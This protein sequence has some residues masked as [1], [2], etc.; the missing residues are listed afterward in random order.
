[1]ART[2]IDYGIDLGTTNSAIALAES[3]RPRIIKSTMLDKDTTPSCVQVNKRGQIRVG[4]QA[5]Y[6]RQ[7]ELVGVLQGKIAEEQVSA[8][9]EFKRTMGTDKRYHTVNMERPFSSEELSAEVLKALKSYVTEE[10]IHAA[11]VTIPAL[12]RQNQVDATLRAAELAGLK[13]CKLLQEPIAASLAYG[14][15]A[16][17]MEGYWLVFDFGGGTFD[18]ALMKVEEGIMKV[19]DTAG[20]NHLGGKDLDLAVVDRILVPWI[21]EK[22]SVSALLSDPVR[23]QHLRAALKAVA[24][25]IKIALSS[26]Q[27]ESY[28]SDEPICEDDDGNEIELDIE[29]TLKDYESAVSPIFQRA[30]TIA[31]DLVLRNKLGN[32]IKAVL[33]VGGPTFSQTLRAMLREEF[34]DII[35]TSIDPMTAVA[36][37]AA[38]FAA[39]QSIPDDLQER[40]ATKIQFTLKYPETTVET[41]E[42]LGIKVARDKT[43]GPVPEVLIVEVVRSDN[44]WSSAKTRIEHADIIDIVLVAGRPNSFEIRVTDE[45]GNTL[46]CEPA[47]FTI[48]QGLQAAKATLPR[49]VCIESVQSGTGFAK[50]AAL[51]GLTKNVSLPAEGRGIFKTQKPIRPGNALDVLRIPIFEGVHGERAAYNELAAQ[52][53]ITGDDI[54]EYLPEGSDVELTVRIDE[55]RAISLSAFFPFIDETV[56]K[57]AKNS[58]GSELKEYDALA[59][60]EELIKAQHACALMRHADTSEIEVGLLTLID[61]LETRSDTDTKVRVKDY[62][63]ELLRKLDQLEE[64]AAWP[65]AEADLDAALHELVETNERFGGAEVGLVIDGLKARAD[66]VRSQRDATLAASLSQQLRGHKF[67]LLRTQIGFWVSYI[68]YYDEDFDDQERKDRSAARRLIDQAK[69]IIATSPSR[70]KIEVIVFNLFELLPDKDTPIISGRDDDLLRT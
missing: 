59:L 8:F 3:G 64:A 34:G 25:E 56:D 21:E 44:G 11:V 57:K 58:R 67:D 24:E 49:T 20:D 55:S 53:E 40:D 13:C 9:I 27:S 17:D 38:I 52:V 29:V 14:I 32:D 31:K 4:Q 43:D 69:Q 39:T 65:E 7:K 47:A 63:N 15:K 16:E 48:I 54:S 35:E 62:L 50:L 10:N 42:H 18:A 30:I 19:P 1:M 36:D 37:G 45:R 23:S 5:V 66:V 28:L 70:D 33:L 26:R 61:Q 51:E 2:K 60:Q 6:G 46:P 12:F 22:Y 41:E 68:K